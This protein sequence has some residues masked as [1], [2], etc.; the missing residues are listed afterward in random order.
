MLVEKAE[1]ERARVQAALSPTDI[2]K[3]T[4]RVM[5]KIQN[6][7]DH[8]SDEWKAL[9]PGKQLLAKF[10][11]RAKLD[12]ARIKISYIKKAEGFTPNP[13]QEIIEIFETFSRS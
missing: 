3:V 6:S 9:I 7:L 11:C 10:A 8:D 4:R 13:F 5:D 1:R 2:E 12:P